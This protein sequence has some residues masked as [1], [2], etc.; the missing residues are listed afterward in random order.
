MN[1][2]AP[3]ARFWSITEVCQAYNVTESW[4]RRQIFLKKVPFVK[5]GRL[6]RFDIND[7]ELWI[8]E[9]KTKPNP[10]SK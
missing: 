5:M 1:Q 10:W 3:Y 4:L 9:A 6:I 2:K 8:M 7:F